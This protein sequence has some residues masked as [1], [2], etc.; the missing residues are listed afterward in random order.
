VSDSKD[1]SKKPWLIIIIAVISAALPSSISFL[2]KAYEIE[3][4]TQKMKQNTLMSFNDMRT[5]YRYISELYS[6]VNAD[7]ILILR[8][9]DSGSV[10]NPLI[11]LYSSIIYEYSLDGKFTAEDWQTQSLDKDYISM[12]TE[13]Y[14]NKKVSLVTKDM[15]ESILKDRFIT[16]GIIHS[17][18]Y[19]LYDDSKFFYYLTITSS[20]ERDTNDLN[21]DLPESE[22]EA[23]YRNKV[24]SYIKKIQS[25][26]Q[27]FQN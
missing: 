23:I 21:A 22:R 4:N 6:L 20:K 8:S 14:Q 18:V 19:Y 1:S 17:D 16:N 9:H 11:P 26:L 3:K 15:D 10:P 13:V 5:I 12:L 7:K 25:V 24:R 27:N 2:T